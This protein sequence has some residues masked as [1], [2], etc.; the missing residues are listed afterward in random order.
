MKFK[1]FKNL[2]ILIVTHKSGN[3][4]DHR[5]IFILNNVFIGDGYS[6]VKKHHARFLRLRQL[7]RY[8]A[9]KKVVKSR[10]ILKKTFKKYIV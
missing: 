8:K 7:I 9:R 4:T 2:P 3:V 5:L 1:I 6:L 10:Q